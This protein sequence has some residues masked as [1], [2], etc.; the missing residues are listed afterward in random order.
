MKRDY[1]VYKQNEKSERWLIGHKAIDTEFQLVRNLSLSLSLSLFRVPMC[2]DMDRYG[3]PYVGFLY[4]YRY[5]YR[6]RY[7]LALCLGLRFHRLFPIRIHYV[8]IHIVIKQ[9]PNN[10]MNIGW[11]IQNPKSYTFLVTAQSISI[12]GT[13]IQFNFIC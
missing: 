4:S 8:L 10:R 7:C 3:F 1:S 5:V 13:P 11:I 6:Y 12:I 9:I 2:I